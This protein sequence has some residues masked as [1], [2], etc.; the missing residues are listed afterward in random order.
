MLLRNRTHE[1]YENPVV[2]F[3]EAGGTAFLAGNQK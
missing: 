3:G 1:V 2:E